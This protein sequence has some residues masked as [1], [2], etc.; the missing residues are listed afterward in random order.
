M[1][2][3]DHVSIYNDDVFQGN[4][5][6]RYMLGDQKIMLNA[7]TELLEKMRGEPG[8]VFNLGHGLTPKTPES[9]VQALVDLV[10]NWR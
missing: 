4:L 9:N 3:Y 8:Y 6:S 2:A 1:I 7:A 5:D 10:Q